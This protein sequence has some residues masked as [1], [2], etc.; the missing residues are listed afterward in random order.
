VS[1]AAHRVAEALAE[2]FDSLDVAKAIR[3]PAFCDAVSSALRV[4]DGDVTALVD[5]VADYGEL[6]GARSPYRVVVARLRWIVEDVPE[7]VRHADERAEA[8]RW[9]RVD[10]AAK[11]GETLRALVERGDIFCDEALGMIGQEF[12]G[13]DDLAG[14]ARAALEGARR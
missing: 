9:A 3:V 11:R 2:R 4:V 13:D 10:R 8:V 6:A 5:E 12:A 14:I 1:G 7:R